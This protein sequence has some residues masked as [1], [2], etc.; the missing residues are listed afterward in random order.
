MRYLKIN[1]LLF[2]CLISINSW[3]QYK[4]TP[5]DS[6]YFCGDHRLA[7]DLYYQQGDSSVNDNLLNIANAYA[8]IGQTDSAIYFIKKQKE[9]WGLPIAILS[10][11]NYVPL[12]NNPE[13]KKIARDLENE[14]FDKNPKLKRDLTKK[15]W[16]MGIDDQL[17]RGTFEFYN[18]KYDKDSAKLDSINKLQANLDSINLL[19]LEKIVKKYGWPKSTEVGVMEASIPF[20]IIE[21]TGVIEIQ[22]K[23]LALIEERVKQNEANPASFAYL[24]DKILI[25][26]NKEQIYGTQLIKNDKTGAYELCPVK[27]VSNID[28]RRAEVGLGPLKEYLQMF[29]IEYGK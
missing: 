19:K 7:I 13:W 28:K 23:Y 12:H 21:H 6:A 15:F 16:Q 11:P 18:K 25:K 29:G 2:A 27:D 9:L 22:K 20:L 17:Y 14:Y 5:A 26:E 3:T 8:F 1:L 4:F 24:T 10:V